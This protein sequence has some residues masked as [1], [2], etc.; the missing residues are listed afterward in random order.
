MQIDC[1]VYETT[2]NLNFR[3]YP[4]VSTARI[5]LIPARTQ[6]P[7]LP[8]YQ[9]SLNGYVWFL[10]KFG[11]EWGFAASNWL[12]PL[13]QTSPVDMEPETLASTLSLGQ[14]L[15]NFKTPFSRLGSG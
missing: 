13:A 3:R 10:V 12:R 15:T 4:D 14:T 5:A 9:L 8:D 6:V 2:A 11:G 1:P 7:R